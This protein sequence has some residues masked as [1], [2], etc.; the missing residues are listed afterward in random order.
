MRLSPTDSYVFKAL[1]YLGTLPP[2]TLAS[3]DAIAGATGVPKLYLVRLL[4]TLGKFQ[5]S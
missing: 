5:N 4:A 1:A 3:S 2:D